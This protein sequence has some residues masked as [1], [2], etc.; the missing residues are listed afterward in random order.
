MKNI[1]YLFVAA[2][3]FCGCSN[4]KTTVET[5]FYRV[6][7]VNQSGVTV[8]LYHYN[9][10]IDGFPEYLV[11]E[12]GKEYSWQIAKDA[13]SPMYQMKVGGV[14][15]L[16]D[17]YSLE[18]GGDK[19]RDDIDPRFFENY[20][21]LEGNEI[22]YRYTFTEADYQNVVDRYKSTEVHYKCIMNNTS[23]VNIDIE[24]DVKDDRVVFPE[25]MTLA[26]DAQFEWNVTSL[27]F[28]PSNP[29]KTSFVNP[30]PVPFGEPSPMFA[31][32]T[33]D[34]VFPV[35]YSVEMGRDPRMVT[36]YV[37]ENVGENSYIYTYT[38]TET[39]YQNAKN[40]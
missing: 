32:I 2:L 16:F 14:R 17:T 5:D 27:E 24:I 8:E 11:L 19:C 26:P 34:R 21:R 29:S 38:F 30:T 6:Q 12:S 7:M 22:A 28:I 40:N 3:A 23:G 4:D 15:V 18:Y 20:E 1:L 36:N 13:I 37:K 10:D 35:E 25:K 9:M 31:K 39:D 33:F